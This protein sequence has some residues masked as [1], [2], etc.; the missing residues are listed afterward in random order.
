M[1]DIKSSG[2]RLLSRR[3]I[4]MI[5]V[6]TVLV[7]T[8]LSFLQLYREFKQEIAGIDHHLDELTAYNRES[9]TR[10]LWHNEDNL[11][12]SILTGLVKHSDVQ[13][14]RLLE[15]NMPRFEKRDGEANNT[16]LIKLPLEVTQD[17]DHYPLGVLEIVGTYDLAYRHLEERLVSTFTTNAIQGLLILGFMY[18]LLHRMFVRHLYAIV[19]FTRAFDFRQSAQLLVLAKK[20]RHEPPDEIDDLTSGINNMIQRLLDSV[21]QL[22]AARDEAELANQAKSMFLSSMS[23][24]LRTPLNAILGFSQVL[25]LDPQQRLSDEQKDQLE[26]ILKGGE[27]LLELINQV[28]DLA[29]IEAG[30]LTVSIENVDPSL[31]IR[32][33][34]KMTEA[35]IGPRNIRVINKCPGQLP[36]IRADLVR[37]KQTLLNL[38]SN[39]VK[40]NVDDGSITISAETEEDG[41]LRLSISDTGVGIARNK[42][43]SLFQP[44][45]R[46]G[47]ENGTIEG[48]GIGLSISR[49]LM[50][51][52]NG[53]IEFTSMEGHGS[54]F[55]IHFPL[56]TEEQKPAVEKVACSGPTVDRGDEVYL[57]QY[58]EDNPENLELMQL[59]LSQQ[60]HV[61]LITSHTA[62]LGL[63]QAEHE[64]PDIILMDINL[65]G[66]DGVEAK[67]ALAKN[68]KTRNIPVIAISANALPKDIKASME[69]GFVKYITKPFK[70]DEVLTSILDVMDT[71]EN[72][73]EPGPQTDASETSSPTLDP[74]AINTLTEA[75]KTLST[76]Y[77][78]IVNRQFLLLGELEQ[79]MRQATQDRN[80]QQ[81]ELAAHQLKATCLTFGAQSLATITLTIEEMAASANWDKIEE[82]LGLWIHEAETVKPLIREA[83]D[84]LSTIP[85]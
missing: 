65:P 33:C 54:T 40:Y 61:Q 23:H 44:F 41:M 22:E 71:R 70:V 50:Q 42:Q 3:F 82:R 2:S 48:T 6:F 26:H 85:A 18:L 20:K 39:A 57:V 31:V 62:E 24:E 60:K 67:K 69:A 38:L 43:A 52:M 46:L 77:L 84:K 75:V 15:N 16:R 25:M 51:M 4:F 66:M 9:I 36:L 81:L 72:H 32:D 68:P 63:V 79:K 74:V 28:L 29:K 35:M 59:I 64:L 55:S 56:S 11:L 19:D 37:F 49:E 21:Q 78:E 83:V 1:P 10:A 30:T 27:H 34:L 5:L 76:P 14:V 73:A 58:I 47:A 13:T 8:S 45:A 17:G 7:A 53:E 12:E 80:A